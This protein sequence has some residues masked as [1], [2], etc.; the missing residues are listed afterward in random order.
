VK[1]YF[2]VGIVAC[3]ELKFVVVVSSTSMLHPTHMK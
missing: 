3:G 2:D 1:N